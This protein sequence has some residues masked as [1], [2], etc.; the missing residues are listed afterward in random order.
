MKV[1]F[2]LILHPSKKDNI[3]LISKRITNLNFD[4]SSITVIMNETFIT[5]RADEYIK[6]RFILNLI[7]EDKELIGMFHCD[8]SVL[9]ITSFEADFFNNVNYEIHLDLI[10]LLYLLKIN[11]NFTYAINK[12]L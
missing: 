9:Q 2:D 7:I 11:L 3:N 1:L 6:M 10:E 5:L 12:S 4:Q 8:Y